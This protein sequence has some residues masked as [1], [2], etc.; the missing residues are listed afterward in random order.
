MRKY[1]LCLMAAAVLLSNVVFAEG[2]L[3][4]YS[5]KVTDAQAFGKE[6]DE[7]MSSDWGKR[8]PADVMLIQQAFNG[9]DEATHSVVMNYAN[10]AD[11]AAGTSA[12]YQAPF[13]EFL[14]KI[15]D[16]SGGVEQSLHQ[17]LVTGGDLSLEKNRVYTIFRM[18]VESPS[19][20]AKAYLKLAKAQVKAGNIEGGYGIRGQVA[21]SNDVYTHYAYLGASNLQS[22]ME[23]RNNLLSSDD[24][25]TF[26]KKVSDNREV[27]S[28]NISIVLKHYAKQ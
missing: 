4:T 17:K 11:M 24:F 10:E 26:N 18:K 21:G 19:E 9:Y 1:I 23:M 7:L 8:F 14:A 25:K 5:V 12:F 6:M 28:S 16:Y 20:Y 13:G 2:Y 27:V 15:S 3:A 22:A